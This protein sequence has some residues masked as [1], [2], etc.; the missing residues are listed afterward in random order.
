MKIS[1]LVDFTFEMFLFPFS[2]LFPHVPSFGDHQGIPKEKQCGS[3]ASLVFSK[4]TW[5]KNTSS[6]ILS[7]LKSQPRKYPPCLL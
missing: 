1:S 2:F 3:L 4:G 6:F 7:L 5:E